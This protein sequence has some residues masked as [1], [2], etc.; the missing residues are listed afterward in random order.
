MAATVWKGYLT[1][2]LI[3]IP[4]RLFTGSRSERVSFHM[5]HKECGTRIKQQ[6]Y[7]PHD[8]RVVERSE[9][10]K[11]YEINK[12]QFVE[13]GDEDL[14][15]VAPASGETMDIQEFVRITDVDPIYFDTSY[16]IVPEEPGRRAYSLLLETMRKTGYAAVAKVA[17][18]QREHVV[19]IRPREQGLTLHTIYYPNEVRAVPEYTRIE[20][21]EL[22]PQE[23]QLAEQLV[24][25]LAGPFD[26]SRYTDEYQK[27]VLELVEAKAEGHAVHAAPQ[28]K[29]APVIDLMAALEKSLGTSG[30]KPAAKA[31]AKKSAPAHS[32]PHAAPKKRA[33][34]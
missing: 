23:V 11:G 17:M 25:S 18:H 12:G 22:K 14:K 32:R 6:L 15:K 31:A 2:G 24:N 33:A 3:S 20:A 9:I 7:C 1:F 5:I 13:I 29:L 8:E 21:A 30:K 26:P 16:Y 28:K 4:I 27:K 10:V 34:G 19:V